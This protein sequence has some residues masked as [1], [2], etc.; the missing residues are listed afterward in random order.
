M[1]VS[2]PASM[3]AN[4]LIP[5]LESSPIQALSSIVN[6]AMKLLGEDTK[7]VQREEEEIIL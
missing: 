5:M 6:N 7:N 4:M 3:A 1:P 2:N